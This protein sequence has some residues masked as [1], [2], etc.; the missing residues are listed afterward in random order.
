MRIG[1]LPR[2]L[3]RWYAFAFGYF[4]LPCFLCGRFAGGHEWKDRA[5]K[6][7]AIPHPDRPGYWHG[8]CP[9][10]TRSGRGDA[11]WMGKL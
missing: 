8:I 11:G 10:C 7:S 9:A 6:S 5:G 2:F 3:H 4:W 1:I